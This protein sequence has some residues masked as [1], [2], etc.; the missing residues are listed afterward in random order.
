VA[1]KEESKYVSI[2]VEL[3]SADKAGAILERALKIRN[4]E[5]WQ[6]RRE[7][8]AKQR[9]KARRQGEPLPRVSRWVPSKLTIWNGRRLES[10]PMEKLGLS[11]LNRPISFARSD[12]YAEEMAAGR[13]YFTP[14]PIVITDEGYVV[15]G[16]HRLGAA[17]AIDWSQAG[18]V[19][20]FLVVWG[21]D[22]KTALLMD[23]A[24]RSA[25]DRRHIALSYA[26]AD[27]RRENAI[28]A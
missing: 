12:L 18:E 8:A 15:N 24:K 28:A 3:V 27:E 13:W 25:D 22:K 20:Q 10:K 7:N 26:G 1:V 16:Q 23:E 19:P 5:L 14:D 21:V 17:D 4:P 11:D 6:T 2:K 9:A